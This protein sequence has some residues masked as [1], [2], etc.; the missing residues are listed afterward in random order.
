M[1]ERVATGAYEL[2]L[3]SGAGLEAEVP[4]GLGIAVDGQER[5]GVP[6]FGLAR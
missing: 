5:G 6:G 4:G 2:G 1:T 3:V